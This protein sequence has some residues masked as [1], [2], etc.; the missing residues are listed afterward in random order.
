MADDQNGTPPESGDDIKNIKS[1]FARKTENLQKMLA[2]QNARSEAMMQ[3]IIQMQ[4]AKAA[5]K[6]DIS[7]SE[8]EL[9]NIGVDPIDDPKKFAKIVTQRATER[10]I[11]A[12]SEQ[13]QESARANQEQQSTLVKLAGE[14]PELNQVDSDLYKKALELS[15]QMPES[16]RNSSIGLKAAVREAAAE[17]GVL[18]VNKRSKKDSDSD[19]FTVD[20]GSSENRRATQKRASKD[21][22]LDPT[23]LAWAE[24]LGRPVNDPKYIESLKKTAQRKDWK[25]YK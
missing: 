19:D 12:A 25:R 10:A 2:D 24:L 4:Q 23:T 17:L 15:R 8:D 14:Y 9:D 13:A 7:T 18:P 20:S 21:D 16:Y 11:K 1:E 22:E 3:A 5:A 6:Q